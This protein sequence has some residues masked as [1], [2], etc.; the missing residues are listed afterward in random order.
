MAENKSMKG[1]E[2]KECVLCG[3]KAVAPTGMD[4]LTYPKNGVC[5]A[6]TKL[7]DL[8]EIMKNFSQL[9]LSYQSR[10]RHLEHRVMDQ[11]RLLSFPSKQYSSLSLFK[12]YS[13]QSSSDMY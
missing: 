10:L 8:D 12:L 2:Y 13:L 11:L 6:C 4:P 1:L 7:P 5:P 9:S 3:R